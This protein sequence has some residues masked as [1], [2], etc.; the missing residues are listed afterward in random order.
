MLQRAASRSRPRI[1]AAGLALALLSTLAVQGA[2]ARQGEDTIEQ[3]SLLGSYL[4]G[5]IARGQHDASAAAAYY[6]AALA[7]DPSN[8]ALAEQSLLMET[9]E[10]HFEGATALAR[11]ILEQQK[12]HRM[13]H[14]V[15]GLAA[16]REKRYGEALEHFKAPGNGVMEQLTLAL[17]RGWMKV[18]QGDIAG[19]TA[20]ADA[21]NQAEWARYYVRYHKALM[22]D[23]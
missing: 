2:A 4:A 7:R 11:Q 18:G 20:D 15:L 6:K 5:R 17:A 9:T 8:M 14:L 19:A 1:L 3:K 23:V 22:Y 16:A 12:D 13:S 10:G 21:I